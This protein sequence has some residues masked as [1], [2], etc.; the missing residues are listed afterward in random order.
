[1]SRVHWMRKHRT[2]LGIVL[3]SGAVVVLAVAFGVLAGIGSAARSAAPQNTSPPTI[4]G[5][6]VAGQALTADPGSWSGTQP[7][8]FGYQWLRCGPDGNGCRTIFGATRQFFN[9]EREDVGRTLRVRVAATN[10]EGSS[11]ATSAQTAVIRAAPSP[12]A[13]PAPPP[14]PAPPATG[15]PRGA[16]PVSVNA[17][18]PPARLIVDQ[19]R[20]DPSVVGRGTKQVVAGFHVSNTCGQ[21]VQGALV[22]ATAVPFNQLSVP[23]EQATDGNGWAQ[24][25][26]QTLAGFPVSRNQ[27]LLALFVRARKQGESVL[28]GISTRRLVSVRVNL[29]S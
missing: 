13:P 6:P 26:F 14:P 1:M 18:T 27:Q 21:A 11:A 2:R 17:V 8:Q 7:I 29:R 15:C 10:R 4:S 24:L 16:G 23:A 9:L 28:A 25:S 22:Y 19:M 20:I 12:P 3:G 5:T